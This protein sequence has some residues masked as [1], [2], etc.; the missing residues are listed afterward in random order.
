[1]SR[2]LSKVFCAW[3]G[4]TLEE[5]RVDLPKDSHGICIEC[6]TG[7]RN[8]MFT[9]WQEEVDQRLFELA[10]VRCSDYPDINFRRMYEMG[11][12]RE[13]TCRTVLLYRRPA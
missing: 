1:M 11:Y 9:Q 12:T 4:K 3:C 13:G 8:V 7:M 6:E 10:G 5:G 2:A